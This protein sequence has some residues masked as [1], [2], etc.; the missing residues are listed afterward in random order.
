[1]KLSILLVIICFCSE[2]FAYSWAE[3]EAGYFPQG[4]SC[5]TDDE[6]ANFK[7]YL[8]HSY[9]GQPYDSNRQQVESNYRIRTDKF[10]HNNLGNE[11][12]LCPAQALS[13]RSNYELEREKSRYGDMRRTDIIHSVR[14]SKRWPGVNLVA[15][16]WGLEV[17][18]GSYDKRIYNMN[19]VEGRLEGD[20][21]SSTI[22]VRPLTLV[23]NPR[24]III[25]MHNDQHVICYPKSMH[26][27]CNP[28]QP[29]PPEQLNRTEPRTFEFPA[30]TSE[31]N[32]EAETESNY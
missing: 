13:I 3:T 6:K 7:Y 17:L 23:P 16:D 24:F 28:F 19:Y 8:S 27:E 14:F 20:M 21:H 2:L 5:M 25:T 26:Q 4:F 18:G 9:S 31:D 15:G 10:F 29:A 22:T 32:S 11:E 30:E 1:M 12:W